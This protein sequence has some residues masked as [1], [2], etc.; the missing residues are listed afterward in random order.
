LTEGLARDPESGAFFVS[1]VHKRKIVRVDRQGHAADFV[2]SGRDGLWGV[3]ALAVDPARGS[4]YALSAPVPEMSGFDAA[5]DGATGV[6]EFDLRTAALRRKVLLPAPAERADRRAFND[7]VIAADGTVYIG[8]GRNGA[9]VRLAPG[10]AAVTPFVPAGRLGSAQGLVLTPS[11]RGLYAADYARG[12]ARVDL[13]SGAV[14]FLAAPPDSVLAGID[15]LAAHGAALVATQNGIKPHRLLLITPNAAEDR[16]ETV[17][18]LTIND[19]RLDEPTLG[20]VVG[21]DFYYIANSQW[22]HFT[23]KGPRLDEL[24]PPAVLKL[25][26]P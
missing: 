22:S 8:D 17:T 10:A 16:L 14:R 1:S 9:I 25:R 18:L 26:L 15:G 5:E 24:R 6:F 20:T 11:G 19:P 12:L 3:F 2:A 7:L 4:L 21:D 13:A 23:D